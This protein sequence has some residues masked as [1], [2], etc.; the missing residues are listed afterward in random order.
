MAEVIKFPGGTVGPV[1][2]NAVLEGAANAALSEVF[3]LGLEQD[4]TEYFASST[5]EAPK[6]LWLLE[7]ARRAVMRE[8]T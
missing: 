8:Q 7:I 6:L 2:V 4:G 3:V 1:P 5:G